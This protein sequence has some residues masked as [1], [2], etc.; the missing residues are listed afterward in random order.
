MSR[1]LKVRSKNTLIEAKKKLGRQVLSLLDSKKLP[2]HRVHVLSE[3]GKILVHE[4][5]L[6]IDDNERKN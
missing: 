5:Y 2:K 3:G 4:R 6:R 1:W